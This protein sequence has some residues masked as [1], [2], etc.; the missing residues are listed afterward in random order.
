MADTPFLLGIVRR[1]GRAGHMAG[2]G[3]AWFGVA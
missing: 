3:M 1:A 2:P